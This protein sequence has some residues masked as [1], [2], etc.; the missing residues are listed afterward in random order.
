M[1]AAYLTFILVAAIL[2]K[3]IMDNPEDEGDDEGY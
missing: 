3:L 1:M 2:A